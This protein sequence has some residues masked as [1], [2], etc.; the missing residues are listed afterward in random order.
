[1]WRRLALAVLILAGLG[2]ILY[3]QRAALH[4]GLFNLTGEEAGLS[5]VRAL[6]QLALDG[7]R[8]PLAL[9]PDVP[10]AYSG[11]NPYG[12]NTFLQHE[13]EPAKRERQVQLIAAAG[14][15]WIRQEFPWSD[16]EISGKGNF[17]DCR[18]GPCHSAWDKYDQI[19]NLA[20]QYGLE[21]IARLSSPPNWSRAD[22]A[23][24]GDYA[25]PDN[26]SDFADFAAAVA[27]RYRGRVHFFQIWNEP[28]GNDEWGYQP[29]DPEAYTR[30]LC[31]TYQRLKD[32]TAIYPSPTL[33]A[34]ALT[35][36]TDLG[37]LNPNGRGG[38]NLNDLVYLQRMYAAG[39]GKCFD[40]MSVQGYGLFSGPTDHRMNPIRINYARNLF[41]RDLMVRNGDEH[42][43]IWISEMNWNTVPAGSGISPDF[44]QVTEDQQARYVPLAYQRAQEEWPWVGVIN[45]WYFKDADDHEQ[46]QAKYY[47]R[48][49]DPDFTLKP[50]YAAMKDYTHQ[51]PVMNA[52]WHSA[53][54]WTVQWSKGWKQQYFEAR[55]QVDSSAMC[56]WSRDP[57]ATA[58]LTFSGT[59]FDLRLL[60]YENGGRL[61][62][63]VDDRAPQT[64]NTEKKQG[65]YD[66]QVLGVHNLP[67][68]LHTVQITSE[69][70]SNCITAF[71]VHR[72]PYRTWLLVA[73]MGLGLGGAWRV[74]RWRTQARRKNPSPAV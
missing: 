1:M 46:N 68:G 23:A 26:F 73:A 5:Q 28:N 64:V 74:I 72:N 70:P 61:Q 71:S 19:V 33:L 20:D 52:G 3:T 30:L 62:V 21:I 60:R 4:A 51:T 31:A 34:A 45:L 58:R 24:R 27:Y 12:V 37:G 44:G 63:Q 10:I 53:D 22:G 39:A 32:P 35:P 66:V 40:I 41:I 48:M 18:N 6:S 14:F 8:P 56:D 43:P 55:L 29:V 13:V 7:W 15:H 54:D 59:D 49:A 38:N 69:G 47:F 50:V 2:L 36:T 42:K 67:D 16:I 17:D 65:F 57:L 25:P 11:V 9:K